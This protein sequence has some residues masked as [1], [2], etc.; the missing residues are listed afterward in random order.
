[1]ENSKKENT[2]K[3]ISLTNIL[4]VIFHRY[5]LL[6]CITGVT[7]L[8]GTL[9]LTIIG[10][11]QETYVSSFK[12]NIPSIQ[13]NK[14]L[15]GS[16]F[17]FQYILSKSNIEEVINSNPEYSNIKIKTLLNSEINEIKYVREYSDVTKEELN[18]YYKLTLPKCV[19]S[20][21]EQAESFVIDLLSYPIKESIKSLNNLNYK[22]N[23]ENYSSALKYED[24]ITYLN[25]QNNLLV[26][27]YNSLINLYGDVSFENRSLSSYCNDVK[28]LDYSLLLSDLSNE[29]KQNGYSMNVEKEKTSLEL[30]KKEIQKTI[31]YNEQKINELR[32]MIKYLL[33]N[34]SSVQSL[35]IDAYNQKIAELLIENV[36]LSERV[37]E[38]DIKITTATNAPT[39]FLNNLENINQ[40]LDEA[41]D[42]YLEV[43]SYLINNYSSISHKNQR[44]IYEENE[45]SIVK[46]A[47][48]S[49]LIGFALGCIVNLIVDR[50]YLFE[51]YPEKK[52]K[53]PKVSEE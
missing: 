13:N 12:Y 1:M 47:L 51:V 40:D 22:I 30:E 28:R 50:K 42:K 33:D 23:L 49:L 11:S 2:N 17:D 29:L 36:N 9:G 44:V 21:K 3:E 27:Q 38:I 52:K 18:A 37:E 41:T 4:K 53:E 8:V 16:N 34:S 14:Y 45:T 48:L 19:F 39:S 32:E 26:A 43:E 7:F 24:Q 20:S 25:N 5:I 10:N 46:N 35:D 15:D 31:Q 6:G